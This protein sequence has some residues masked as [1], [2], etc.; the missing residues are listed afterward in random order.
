[1]IRFEDLFPST[2]EVREA[3]VKRGKV[4]LALGVLQVV[5][6]VRFGRHFWTKLLEVIFLMG[7]VVW[8]RVSGKRKFEDP[9]Y[10]S[11]NRPV[12]L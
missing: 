10:A 6:K 12:I 1:M 4:Q 8:Y 9:E 2:G 5:Y 7:L 11:D 3:G